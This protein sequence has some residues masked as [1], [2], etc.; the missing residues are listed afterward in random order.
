MSYR[1]GEF[2][3]LYLGIPRV[4]LVNATASDAWETDLV[5]AR[6]G[7]RAIRSASARQTA[8]RGFNPR[9]SINPY[10]NWA[11]II[12]CGDIPVTPFDNAVAREQ[13][14]QAL[15]AL[16][17][18]P[19]VS[20]LSP[21]PKLMTLGGDHSLTLP[22]LRALNKIHGRPVRVLHFD[23]IFALPCACAHV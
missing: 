19:G 8:F 7:P 12:D 21:K 18:R 11:K 23:G 14:T 2:V 15:T 1:P 4:S 16:G 20:A 10:T 22:A 5:G 6:F 9:A 17:E 3:S 13:M